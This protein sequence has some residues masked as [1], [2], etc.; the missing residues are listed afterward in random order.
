MKLKPTLDQKLKAQAIGNQLLPTW[1]TIEKYDVDCLR[2]KES[3][4]NR[5]GHI[6]IEITQPEFSDQGFFSS[7]FYT[8]HIHTDT[9]KSDVVWWDSDFNTLR[10]IF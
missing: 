9:F 2:S 1:D 3:E 8:F 7:S 6:K 4:L 10:E 5:R